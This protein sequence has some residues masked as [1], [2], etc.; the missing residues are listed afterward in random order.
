MYPWDLVESLYFSTRPSGVLLTLN[1]HWEPIACLP[2][3]SSTSS[4]VPFEICALI[5]ASTASIHLLASGCLRASASVFGSRAV[6]VL[7]TNSIALSN[8]IGMVSVVPARLA[9]STRAPGSQA[10]DGHFCRE[11]ICRWVSLK[12][13]SEVPYFRWCLQL[14]WG[15]IHWCRARLNRDWA[16][17]HT[18]SHG[19]LG[20]GAGACTGRVSS[21]EGSSGRGSSV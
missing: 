7:K 18:T 8:G 9:P 13:G 5:S 20:V 16:S 11:R 2:G 15:V 4:H 1:T 12:V 6:V 17:R 14:F 3:G 21:T 19:G 10:H